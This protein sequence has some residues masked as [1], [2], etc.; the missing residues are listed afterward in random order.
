MDD[1]GVGVYRGRSLSGATPGSGLVPDPDD[2][3]LIRHFLPSNT[4]E[5]GP[6]DEHKFYLRGDID[7]VNVA[8][9]AERLHAA[10]SRGRGNLVVDCTDLGFISLAGFRLLTDLAA[11]LAAQGGSLRLAHPTR[12]LVRLL[13]V[14]GRGELIVQERATARPAGARLV[15]SR[16]G[17]S[18]RAPA[19]R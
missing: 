1:A 9:V 17:N 12:M 2:L 7:L 18:R 13:D 11:E 16:L 8:D 3:R 10:A 19:S 15:R 6:V 14:L 4:Q 5:N